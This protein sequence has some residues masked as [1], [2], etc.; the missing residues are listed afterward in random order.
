MASAQEYADYI[1]RM[2]ALRA[3]RD[4]G[5]VTTPQAVA[6]AP[7]PAGMDPVNSQVSTM[8]QWGR[9]M[10]E[11]ASGGL[12]Q[13]GTD[14]G[15]NIATSARAVGR[16]IVAAPSVIWNGK[17][18]Q[19]PA[20]LPPYMAGTTAPAPAVRPT[21]SAPSIQMGPP[22]MTVGSGM[23][24]KRFVVGNGPT[25]SIYGGALVSNPTTNSV[26]TPEQ[27]RA[28]GDG[29]GAGPQQTPRSQIT[30]GNTNATQNAKAAA[31]YKA[32]MAGSLER[33]KAFIADTGYKAPVGTSRT[34]EAALDR[35]ANVDARRVSTENATKENAAERQNKLDVANVM[36]DASVAAAEAKKRDEMAM[37]PERTAKVRESLAKAY[38]EA[39]SAANDDLAA[40]YADQLKQLDQAASAPKTAA[41]AEGATAT[42]KDGKKIKFVGGKWIPA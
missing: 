3:Q 40:F 7:K 12:K 11:S 1:N 37:T 9:N 42:G 34:R 22:D 20:A 18:A 6:V 15:G 36:G 23:V 21:S 29:A 19:A 4:A 24:P 28:I 25:N 10:A 32:F 13:M 30:F 17:N 14:I 2:R 41:I 8:R 31:D 5:L 27:I 26:Y 38:G 33:G 16:G 39:M 35:Q